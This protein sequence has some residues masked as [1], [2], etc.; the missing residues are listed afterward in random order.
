[1]PYPFPQA[2]IDQSIDWATLQN[3][4]WAADMAKC[5]QDP[6]FH[7]EGDVWTHTVMVC[8]EL[9]GLDAWR[10][11]PTAER[12]LVFAACLLHDVAKPACTTIIDGRIRQPR[13]SIKG[14]HFAR[15]LLWRADLDPHTREAI[16]GLIRY[17]QVP[18]FCI[19][20]AD[21]IRR[22]AQVSL[23]ARCDHLALVN[24]ADALG[25]ICAD[26]GALLDNL[27]LFVELAREQ[28][29]LGKAF[30]FPSAHTRYTYFHA[31]DRDPHTLA[32]EDTRCE[33]VLMCGLPGSGKDTWIADNLDLPV[34]SLDAIRR[35]LGQAPSGNPRPVL[36]LA[37]ERARVRL[38]RAEAFVWNATNLSRRIRDR[39]IDLFTNY[40]ARARLVYVEVP[41]KCLLEQN[42][43]RR[44]AVPEALLERMTR[45]WDP[46]DASEAHRV[47]WI[48]S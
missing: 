37:R 9:R 47:D 28:Q 30:A 5:P 48:F 13:H 26:K 38:R 14:A 18:F 34:I 15:N 32:Y 10:S 7:G 43:A 22:I 16:A 8:E 24:R 20:D 29:C 41:Y 2:A 46:P 19:D 23:R 21:P 35:E 27:D 31:P 40:G 4:T 6:E 42:R 3:E 12:E 39:V 1:M 25:R 11:L 36:Q 33:V 45:I 44:A 17:H